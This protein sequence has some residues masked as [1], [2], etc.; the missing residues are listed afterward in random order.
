MF[1]GPGQLTGP[2]DFNRKITMG[3]INCLDTDMQQKKGMNTGLEQLGGEEII[4][5]LIFL[6]ELSL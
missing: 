5:E 4:T 2:F 6:G 1:I 3:P